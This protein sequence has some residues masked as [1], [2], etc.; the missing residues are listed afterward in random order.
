MQ[1]NRIVVTCPD[2]RILRVSPSPTLTTVAE[3]FCARI[4]A[5]DNNKG[6]TKK[7]LNNNLFKGINQGLGIRDNSLSKE[8]LE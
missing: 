5:G 1:A 7:T 6:R 4:G 2:S 8:I 3:G